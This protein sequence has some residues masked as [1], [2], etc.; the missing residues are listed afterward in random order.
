MSRRKKI[1]KIPFYIKILFICI[2]CYFVYTAIVRQDY[3][4][5]FLSINLM[6][7]YRNMILFVTDIN[8]EIIEKEFFD[9]DDD[10]ELPSIK[11]N[12][13]PFKKIVLPDTIELEPYPDPFEEYER[14]KKVADIVKE[15]LTEATNK[16]SEVLNDGIQV[17]RKQRQYTAN[18]EHRNI[19]TYRN[20]VM[21]N[22][23]NNTSASSAVKQVYKD[24]ADG[25][26]NIDLNLY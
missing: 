12:N 16:V 6:A 13:E 2:T 1:I 14:K 19:N 17:N 26:I 5:A 8:T 3:Y 20:N 24:I 7:N 10:Y 23:I 18:N 9:I 25:I 11:T 15:K 21:N 4:G 22:I